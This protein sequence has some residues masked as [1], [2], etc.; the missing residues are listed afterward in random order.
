VFTNY[1]R[2]G[3]EYIFC[4][5]EGVSVA[6]ENVFYVFFFFIASYACFEWVKVRSAVVES[7]HCRKFLV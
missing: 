1:F 4:Y 7:R 3:I 6:V 5:I 2:E